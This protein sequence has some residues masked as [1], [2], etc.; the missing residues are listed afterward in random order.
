[1]NALSI[2]AIGGLSL[3]FLS[4]FSGGLCDN[5]SPNGGALCF[6]GF[7]QLGFGQPLGGGGAPAQLQSRF[8]GAVLN[9]LPGGSSAAGGGN[10]SISGNKACWTSLG[11]QTC[12]TFNP[13]SSTNTPSGRNTLCSRVRAKF[14]STTQSNVALAY[15]GSRIS[16][17]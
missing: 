5:A 17:T 10:C 2:V 13:S 12:T 7:K 6:H 1:V 14:L 8:R 4:Y 11:Q 3:L 15:V 9:R 16:V